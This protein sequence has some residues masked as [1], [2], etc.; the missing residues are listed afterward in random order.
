MSKDYTEVTVYRCD[1]CKEYHG[2]T[3]ELIEKHLEECIAN[4]SNEA[5]AMCKHCKL[6]RDFSEEHQMPIANYRCYGAADK[7]LDETDMTLLHATCFELR[8]QK[9][10]EQVWTPAF[11]EYK[12]K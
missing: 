7:I 3:E 6:L 5:C 2:A 8:E 9:K 10:I 4:P 1:H 12:A 11:E